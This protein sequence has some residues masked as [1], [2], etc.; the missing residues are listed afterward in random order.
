MLDF[1]K[2]YYSSIQLC[3]SYTLFC[4]LLHSLLYTIERSFNILNVKKYLSKN[5]QLSYYNRLVSTFH[6][7]IMFANS[8]QYWFTI[9]PSL[10]ITQ[11][12]SYY[13]TKCVLYMIGYLIYDTM[14][15]LLFTKQIDTLGHHVL[16]I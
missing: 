12:N 16:G 7:C 10:E 13:Q 3:L 9:N 14:F 8:V 15:E 4:I 1:I 2:D 6:A 11:Y 5:I